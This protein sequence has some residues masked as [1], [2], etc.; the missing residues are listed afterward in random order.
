MGIF[1]DLLQED[2][3]KKQQKHADSLEDRVLNLET[4][5]SKTQDLLR[6]TLEALEKHVEIDID[7]DGKLG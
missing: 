4:E 6:K 5:L 3:L 2:E 7:G 1:W